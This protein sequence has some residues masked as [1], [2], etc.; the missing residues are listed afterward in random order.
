M[1][2]LPDQDPLQLR[3][4]LHCIVNGLGLLK[5]AMDDGSSARCDEY[6]HLINQSSNLLGEL[7]NS[8]LD[9][10]TITQT[11]TN[12]QLAQTEEFDLAQAV[13]VA[14]QTSLPRLHRPV[15]G[16]KDVDVLVEYEDRDWTVRSDATAFKR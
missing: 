14:V 13:T 2:A 16:Q 12:E 11:M 5:E 4:P 3:T 7:L 10:G 8:M 1:F 9:F 15:K 6:L